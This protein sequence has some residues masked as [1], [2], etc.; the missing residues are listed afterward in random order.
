MP[1]PWFQT[2]DKKSMIDNFEFVYSVRK[3]I[4]PGWVYLIKTHEYYKVGKALDLNKRVS[5]YRTHSPCEVEL[6]GSRYVEDRDIFEEMLLMSFKDFLHRGEWF[7][8]TDGS[9]EVI[10][11]LIGKQNGTKTNN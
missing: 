4:N 10:K 3:R 5:S 7:D 1:N 2:I 9:L 8:F 6:I 11:K